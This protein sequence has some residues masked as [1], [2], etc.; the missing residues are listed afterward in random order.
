[1]KAIRLLS[2]YLVLIVTFILKKGVLF[3]CLVNVLIAIVEKKT[4][5]DGV[6]DIPPS[7]RGTD[8]LRRKSLVVQNIGDGVFDILPSSRD[9][10]ILR[11]KILVGQNVGDGVLNIP[12]SL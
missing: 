8:I 9:A 4:V 3:V 5:G 11:R 12:P 2:L 7:M 6:L 10:D 1:M